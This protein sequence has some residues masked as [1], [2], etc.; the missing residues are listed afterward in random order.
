MTKSAATYFRNLIGDRAIVD[1]ERG[2]KFGHGS[3]R[4][5]STDHERDEQDPVHHEQLCNKQ[6]KNDYRNV[7]RILK[8]IIYYFIKALSYQALNTSFKSKLI[9]A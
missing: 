7:Q 1:F 2:W 3:F 8:S 9:I 4:Q 5:D 6:D